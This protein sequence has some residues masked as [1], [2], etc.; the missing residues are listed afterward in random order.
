MQCLKWLLLLS[1]LCSCSLKPKESHR[2][3]IQLNPSGVGME[4]LRTQLE[5][6]SYFLGA[7]VAVATPPPNLAG[8]YCLGVNIVG[9]GI[10]NQSQNPDPNFNMDTLL[11]RAK[12][13]T[14]PGVLA[15]PV[16]FS[17]AN[18]NGHYDFD[19]TVPAGASR[20]I[21]LFGLTNASDCPNIMTTVSNHINGQVYE[22]GRA[23]ADIFQDLTVGVLE[24]YSTASP[25]DQANR[26][27][28][29][30][31]GTGG[32][33]GGGCG[34]SMGSG[35]TA[36]TFAAAAGFL[37]AQEFSLPVGTPAA[38]LLRDLKVLLPT[39]T[40]LPNA[41]HM[42]AWILPDSGGAPS[43]SPL[44]IS[45]TP[46]GSTSTYVSP[47]GIFNSIPFTF[48]GTMIFSPGVNYWLVVSVS[49]AIPLALGAVSTQY[50]NTVSNTATNWGSVNS[51]TP[52]FAFQ[53]SACP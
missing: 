34:N 1:F 20:L 19:L 2:V 32:G 4:S 28:N 46:T 37:Y 8:F 50:Y 16:S 22:L 11:S 3:S 52:S 33:T 9:P 14:Y 51:G 12:S 6:P 15:G 47:G 25:V 27:M 48:N 42:T 41:L 38:T 49:P 21:Q 24:D 13:C 39:G 5:R 36:N 45:T 26:L 30:D 44:N 43:L 35:P 31:N 7:A 53:M 23:K 29:C 17:G 40:N 18:P 10:A